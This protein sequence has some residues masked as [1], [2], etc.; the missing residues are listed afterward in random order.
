MSKRFSV[1]QAV[2]CLLLMMGL[3]PALAFAL[4][5][6][7]DSHG[8][9]DAKLAGIFGGF[10]V[11]DLEVQPSLAIHSQGS[12]KSLENPALQ[13]FFAFQSADW[14]VRWDERN[15]R[16]NLIQ[17]AGIPLLPGRG[18]KL[19]LAD[20]K[21]GHE[22]GPGL[23]DV[24]AKLR[25]FMADF[26]ELLNVGSFDLRL[27]AKSTVNVGDVWFVEFQQ[28]HRGLPVEGAKVFFRINNGNIVQLGTERVAEVR[29]PATP[30][31][32]RVAALAA[33]VQALGLRA[34]EMGEIRTPGTLKFVPTLT[35]GEQPAEKYAGLP[36]RGY[37][38][39]AGLGGGI[40]PR[41][42][43]RHLAGQG[44]R[45]GRARSSR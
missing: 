23:A 22:G 20:L 44:G 34:E 16:P 40:P 25:G 35:A 28:F 31:I 39:Q 30:K 45:P 43:H 3:V 29:V 21:L 14:E 32:G 24:E 27:D 10:R 13:R 7:Q 41:R 36:G 8:D 11:P 38:S 37:R 26:P 9:Q 2:V 1:A 33:A 17:G 19:A 42:R 18:N 5:A 6:P 4:I 15:N 12:Q